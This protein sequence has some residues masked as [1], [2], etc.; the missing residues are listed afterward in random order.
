MLK[1]QLNSWE[2]IPY[3]L[4]LQDSDYEARSLFFH[5]RFSTNTDSQPAMAQP[6]RQMAHNG[7]LNTDKK[8]RL[9]EDAIARTK[10]RRIHSPVGQSDSARL[11]QTLS[12]RIHEDELDMIEA[13][14]AMMPPAWENDPSIPQHVRDISNISRCTRKRTTARRR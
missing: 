10:N 12:R 8:N 1:G 5:T 3:F 14:I 4:D 6:F 13:V 2:V 11:D 9:S 7:E